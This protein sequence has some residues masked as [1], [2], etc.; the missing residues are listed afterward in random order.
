MARIARVIIPGIP[1]HLTQR[2]GVP[3]RRV[4]PFMWFAYIQG[5]AFPASVSDLRDSHPAHGWLHLLFAG[6]LHGVYQSAVHGL[7][8]P[9]FFKGR[10]FLSPAG[11]ERRG[12]QAVQRDTFQP[13]AP[14]YSHSGGDM[15][16]ETGWKKVVL[17]P[18]LYFLR[19]GEKRGDSPE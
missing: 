6:G 8:R 7:R 16:L 12:G 2:G 3:Q 1:H 19:R 9:G 18:I 5:G 4:H 11:D 17:A 10:I 13:G 14:D 15:F